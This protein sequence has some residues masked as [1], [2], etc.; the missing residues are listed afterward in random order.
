MN[1][2][3]V[4]S[5]RLPICCLF[6]GECWSGPYTAEYHKDGV[7]TR[8][9]GKNFDTCPCNSYHCVGQAYA[10]YVYKLTE[11]PTIPEKIVNGRN[12]RIVKDYLDQ[13]LNLW[14][15]Q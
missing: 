5:H 3:A 11:G 10:N 15:Y 13:V 9:R 4:F 12:Q 14:D 7:S 8:C 1:T 2:L 6:L